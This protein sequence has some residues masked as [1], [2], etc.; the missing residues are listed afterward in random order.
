[1]RY[2]VSVKLHKNFVEVN[3][4]KIAVGVISAPEKGKANKELVAKIAGHFGVPKSAVR[5]IAG[6]SSRKKIIEI[7]I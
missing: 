2:S 6:A 4:D 7:Q 1:M 3:G 5:I